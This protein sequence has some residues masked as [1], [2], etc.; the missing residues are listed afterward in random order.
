M[1]LMLV[2]TR[3]QKLT[4]LS[5]NKISIPTPKEEKKQKMSPLIKT[6]NG[7]GI[8]VLIA[9]RDNKI[10]ARAEVTEKALPEKN[11]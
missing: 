2:L 6:D 10:Y 4:T 7:F 11:A 1:N 5:C 9:H 8:V 3:N